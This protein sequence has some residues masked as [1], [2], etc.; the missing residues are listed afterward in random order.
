MDGKVGIKALQ[1]QF[2]PCFPL[3]LFLYSLQLTSVYKITLN[4][5]SKIFRLK[6]EGCLIHGSKV[7]RKK[8][9]GEESRDQSDPAFPSTC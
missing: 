7:R 5:Q 4:F 6:I 2:D 1:E 3:H 8:T 9:S